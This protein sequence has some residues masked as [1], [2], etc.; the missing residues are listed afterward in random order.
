MSTRG[1]DGVYLHVGV[2]KTGTTYLQ[3]F[4]WTN[5]DRLRDRGLLLALE[6]QADHYAAVIDLQGGRF[7]G[8]EVT[9]VEGAWPRVADQAVR[10]PRRSLISHEIFGGLREAKVEEVF[11]TLGSRPVHVVL[12]LRDLAR[13][14]PAV[15]QESAKNQRVDPW[16]EFLDRVQ[17]LGKGR[18][19]RFWRLQNASRILR[20]WAEFVPGERIHVVTLP[21]PGAPRTMLIE[22]FCAAFDVDTRGLDFDISVANESIGAAEVALLQRINT[23]A[24]D[25][26][27]W[28]DYHDYLKH[29]AVPNILAARADSTRV[30]MPDSAQPWLQ[31]ETQRTCATISELGCDVIGDLADLTP[32]T[33]GEAYV[34][35]ASV[36]DD[37]VL[38]AAVDLSIGMVEEYARLSRETKPAA[39]VGDVLKSVRH[40]RL[41]DVRDAVN[42]VQSYRRERRQGSAP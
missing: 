16:P 8:H 29:F 18:D 40:G 1:E 25:R 14:V 6:R 17:V 21:P 42:R 38:Q 26:M 41:G 24:V 4:L 33:A 11:E 27:S 7:A 39:A 19:R 3:N 37:E 23:T 28:D 20:T 22:R 10:W 31:E 30:T 36:T 32:R 12:T 5:R 15:W 34:D 13:I 35:P 9:G 2:P